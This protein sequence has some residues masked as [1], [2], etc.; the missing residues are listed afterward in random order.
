MQETTGH[1]FPL[2]ADQPPDEDSPLAR[3]PQAEPPRIWAAITVPFLAI[4]VGSVIAAVCLVAAIMIMG[5]QLTPTNIESATLQLVAQPIGIWVTVLP[6]QLVFLAAAFGAAMLSPVPFRQRLQMSPS[7]LPVWTWAVFAVGTP[8]IGSFL[9]LMVQLSGME[10]S[11]HLELMSELLGGKSG[12]QLIVTAVLVAAVPGY[13]EETLFRG[14]LQSR[15][16]QRW[17]PAAAIVVSSLIFGIAHL[18]PMHV[19]LVFP[20][21]LW[22]GFVAWRCGSIWPAVICHMANNLVSVV[23]VQLEIEEPHVQTAEFLLFVPCFIALMVSFYL[24]LRGDTPDEQDRPA[25]GDAAGL[26]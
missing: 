1:E 23:M 13:V 11:K 20:I 12:T 10:W 25:T 26:C 22:L 8:A 16:L 9:S 17:S 5:I 7:R 3:R 15:L 4:I 21:G 19:M 18:D 6:G 14:Y 24:L 2:S